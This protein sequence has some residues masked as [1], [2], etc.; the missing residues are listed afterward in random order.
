MRRNPEKMKAGRTLSPSHS[1]RDPIEHRLSE[2]AAIREK[3][4][5]C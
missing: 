5:L 4:A 3:I 1:L 2:R